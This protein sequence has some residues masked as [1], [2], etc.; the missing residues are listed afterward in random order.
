MCSQYEVI[1]QLPPPLAFASLFLL[2]NPAS[3]KMLH[4]VVK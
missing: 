2:L 3:T 4:F 1:G